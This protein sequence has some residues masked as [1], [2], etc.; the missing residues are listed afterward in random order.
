MFFAF[1]RYLFPPLLPVPFLLMASY[2]YARGSKRLH[3]ALMRN[4]FI[5]PS[6]KDWEGGHSMSAPTKLGAVTGTASGFGVSAYTVQA[7]IVQVFLLA[8]G[9]GAILYILSR[10]APENIDPP[11]T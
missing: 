7:P 6:L 2:C 4:R 11:V 9:S 3:R 8:L 5:G 10:P 1:F